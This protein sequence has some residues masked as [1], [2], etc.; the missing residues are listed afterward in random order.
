MR[1]NHTLL[2]LNNQRY[3]NCI[4]S[5][6]NIPIYC[7]VIIFYIIKLPPCIYSFYFYT[8]CFKSILNNVENVAL[9]LK[10]HYKYVSLVP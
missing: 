5:I 7:K 3:C 4:N 1:Y 9:F 8:Y 6:I 2:T 10:A